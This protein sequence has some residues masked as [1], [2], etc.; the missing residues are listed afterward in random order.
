MV[1]SQYQRAVGV[2]TH[3]IDAE[4]AIHE[5]RASGLAMEKVSILVQNSD[6]NHEIAANEVKEDTGDKADEGATVGG[7]SGGAVGGL[8]GLLVGSWDFSNPW[9][10]P[11]NAGWGGSN[12]FGYNPCWGKYWCCHW[13]FCWC[14][15]WLGNVV[16]AS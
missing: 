14:I 7:L 13:D 1:L 11:N 12:C 10:W 3:R 16:R 4:R 6:R 2:F 9:N 8:T 5:L 15:S